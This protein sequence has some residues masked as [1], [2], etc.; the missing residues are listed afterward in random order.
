MT[1]VLGIL[2][3]C[4]GSLFSIVVLAT[5]AYK[6]LA[7]RIDKY[8]EGKKEHSKRYKFPGF[9][10]LSYENASENASVTKQGDEG[11]IKDAIVALGTTER[12]KESSPIEGN[13]QQAG[14]P[15]NS[16][17]HFRNLI[18]QKIN[19][20]L[21]SQSIQLIERTGWMEIKSLNIWRKRYFHLVGTLLFYYKRESDKN[22]NVDLHSM[23]DYMVVIHL[24]D[25][26]LKKPK[27]HG[28]FRIFSYNRRSN[29]DE[30]TIE[31]AHPLKKNIYEISHQHSTKKMYHINNSVCY[32]KI[33]GADAT[34]WIETLEA[35]TKVIIIL[36]LYVIIHPLLQQDAALTKEELVR[37]H[38]RS[39]SGRTDENN[40]IS[41][42]D[43]MD[44]DTISYEV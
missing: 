17:E 30:I 22:R 27:S 24:Q 11:I 18:S 32:L 31:L 40:S 35:A 3:F 5:V 36:I 4:S 29:T 13:S 43:S 15:R 16:S 42:Y 14:S 25:C 38:L 23:G 1:I 33:G 12:I 6:L 8:E 19:Q 10:N 26:I 28:L 7:K 20:P 21:N 9:A 41:S 37:R 39:Q 34:E 44:D 2:L